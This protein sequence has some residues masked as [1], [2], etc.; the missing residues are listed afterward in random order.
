[1]LSQSSTGGGS[2]KINPSQTGA[3]PAPQFP[4]PAAQ[5]VPPPNRNSLGSTFNPSLGIMGSSILQKLVTLTAQMRMG[6]SDARLRLDA[7]KSGLVF[8]SAGRVLVNIRASTPSGNSL[9]AFSARLKTLG[10]VVTGT[11]P[12]QN[13]VTGY[14]PVSS[15]TQL[16]LVPQFGAVTPVYAP[17]FSASVTSEGNAVIGA[18]TFRATAGVDGTGLTVGVLSDSVGKVG[19]GLAASESTGD[20]PSSLKV[21]Q[22]GSTGADEGRAMLQ[23]IHGVAPGAALAF[24]TAEGGPQAMAQAIQTLATTGQAKVIA[25]DALYPDEPFY[26]DGL[27]AQTVDSVAIN[28]DV[29]YVTAA[30]NNADHAFET[31]FSPISTS[32]GGTAGIYAN[33]G[34]ASRPQVLQHFSLAAGKTFDA[35]L[36]WDSAFLE[37]GSD[38][39]GFQVPNE[40]DVQIT[41]AQGKVVFDSF[42]D[43]TQN[44]GEALQRIL[45]TNTGD[46]GTTDFAL[47][48]RLTAGPPPTHLKWIRF[49]SNAPAEFQGGS[50]IF[51]HAAAVNALTVGAVPWNNIQSPEPF[52]SQGKATI[53]F[54]ANGNR[55]D[56]PAVRNKPDVVGPDGVHT[57][58]FP[59]NTTGIFTGTSAAA[60]HLAGSAALQRS[61]APHNGYWATILQME[62]K[63][64]A[65]G[66][67]G[68]NK[69]TGF[70]LDP[71]GP[72]P[73]IALSGSAWTPI[74]PASIPSGQVAGGG[75]VSGRVAGLAADPSNAN[76]LYMAAAG[77]GV[78]KTTD[79]GVTWTPLTD[80]QQ[81][82]FMGAI[83]VAP[84]NGNTIYA[85]TGESTDSILSFYGRGV[86]KSTDGGAT[87]TLQNA[88]GN[89]DRKTIAKIVVSNTTDQ[90]VYLALH[91]G[92]IN[93]TAGNTG[94]WKSTDG[95]GTWTNTTTGISG[96][97]SSSY[98]SDLVIDPGNDQHL[99]TAIGTYFGDTT[100]GI[101]ETTDGGTTWKASGNF[102][103]GSGLGNIKLAISTSNTKVLFASISDPTTNGILDVYQTTDGGTT[104]NKV[105]KPV[106]YLGSQGFYDTYVA[107]DPANAKTVFLGGSFSGSNALGFTNQVLE[108]T[109]SGTTWNDITVDTAGNGVH[110]DHHAYAFDANGKLIDG[111]DGGV[112]RLADSATATLTWNDLN[113]NLGTLQF[114]G[115]GLDPTNANVAYSGFQDNGTNKFTGSATGWSQ[116][117]GGDGGFIRVD[118]N[119]PMTVYHTFYYSGPGFIE[120]SD[121]GGSTWTDISGGINTADP[122][123]FYPPYV[124]DP[125]NSSRLLLGTNNV[126]ETTD[127]GATWKQ[128][129]TTNTAGYNTTADVAAIA[130]AKT[131]GNTVY[132]ASDNGDIWATT[133]DGVSWSQ[134]NI[135][136]VSDHIANLLVDPTNSQIVYAVRDEFGG[137]HVFQ[138][139]NGGTSW[140][141]IS[142]NLPDLPTYSIAFDQPNNILYVGND[143]GVY[144]STNGGTS[145]AVFGTGLPNVQVRDLELNTSLGILAAGTHGRSMWE[146]STVGGGSGGGPGGGGT[147]A[148]DGD[149]SNVTSDTATDFGVSSGTF[150]FNQAGIYNTP[151]GLP[152]YDWYRWTMADSGTFTATLNSLSPGALEEHVFLLDT[153]GTLVE[154]GST[155]S[156]SIPISVAA[157]QTMM[158]EVKGV[159]YAPG[160]QYQ[161][162]YNLTVVVP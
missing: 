101:Y 94:V 23:I 6:S 15:I 14:L 66:G 103:T 4:F 135:S 30:G 63:A 97:S 5:M 70:G 127:K 29:L 132:V 105:T 39:P 117:R 141:D 68:W 161:A 156:G 38:Q 99:Y 18:D 67:P 65:I 54:D 120:R 106:N 13:M 1:M 162:S 72:P 9:G 122:A 41:D 92:G 90:T 108:S 154:L 129:A 140:T 93:G 53:L 128:I 76:I 150:Q 52:T 57:A 80:N 25:D 112:W 73:A 12:T 35:V 17:H 50:T 116:V 139:T 31:T 124:M 32:V 51:G 96:V 19:N 3:Q 43:K 28:N 144:F 69:V 100:N 126:Y 59:G 84:S 62:H 42:N 74:G 64:I 109:D 46:L 137:G 111:N 33:L 159:P 79:G 113:A 130:I 95:G 102:P 7:L 136:G 98:F 49:D 34:T 115:M 146:I 107:V 37:G 91:N 158:V 148:G 110:A 45:F 123:E 82:L 78:W 22:D 143:S 86:L 40:V 8:D 27:L 152:D 133:N 88:G 118:Y 153:D 85:G 48:F 155:T 75:A 11:T 147:F 47:S 71:V 145:W 87:W 44:T 24:D 160:E 16:P 151:D 114:I 119:N 10:L 61:A 125:T 121:D 131:N 81:T 104:W 21:F 134:I 26:N 149:E 157:G 89:F 2:I 77:G 142:G 20:L 83:A 60:A 55:L 138:T 56:S 58:N 36:Q